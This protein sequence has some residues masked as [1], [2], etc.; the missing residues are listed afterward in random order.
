[1]L[2]SIFCSSLSFFFLAQCKHCSVINIGLRGNKIPYFVQACGISHK[3]NQTV[4]NSVN[5]FAICV[6]C[7]IGQKSN[8]NFVQNAELR[9][10]CV[11]NLK[12]AEI[13]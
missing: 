6:K 5:I 2:N 4:Q 3:L 13:A 9:V 11:H 1:M 7:G 10:N 12:N 8:S